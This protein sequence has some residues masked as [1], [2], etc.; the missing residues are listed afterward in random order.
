MDAVVNRIPNLMDAVGAGA[1]QAT[2]LTD[3]RLG[4]KQRMAHRIDTAV[5]R[6]VIENQS[7]TMRTGHQTAFTATKRAALQPTLEPRLVAANAAIDE[8]VGDLDKVV[9]SEVSPPSPRAALDELL[10]LHRAESGEL[11]ALLETRL[12]GI[13]R[14]ARIVQVAILLGLLLATYL[15]VGFYLSVAGSLARMR[16]AVSAARGGDFTRT[17]RVTTRDEVATMAGE[18][19]E[20]LGDLRGVVADLAGKAERLG[21]ASSRLGTVAAQLDVRAAETSSQA[22]TARGDAAQVDS[23][24]QTMS[25]A[26]EQMSASIREIAAS[27]SSATT[28]AGQAVAVAAA[29]TTSVEGL[30][31]ASREIGEIVRVITAVA[32]QTN[33]LALNA[34]IEAARAGEAGKGFAVVAGEVKELASETARA[35]EDIAG[36]IVGIQS[37]GGAAADGIDKIARVIDDINATQSSIAAAIEE[38]TATTAEIARNVADVARGTG[39]IVTAVAGVTQAAEATAG[40]AVETRRAAD[41]LDVVARDLRALAGRF[42]Y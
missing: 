32:E 21:G 20:L 10:A 42:R 37:S 1:A 25:A 9:T 24:V 19:D 27:A 23:H 6:G 18:L 22:A 31:Q 12:A 11:N 2:L 15:F 33:L 26:S 8:V 40:D 13:G 14:L 38:Q 35:T 39:S 29:T 34:T 17:A 36:R 28:V 4:D 7:A 30:G 3:K 16:A 41:D 5:L